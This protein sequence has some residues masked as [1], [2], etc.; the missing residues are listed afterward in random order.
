MRI[1]PSTDIQGWRIFLYAIAIWPMTIGQ[2]PLMLVAPYY[3]FA[4]GMSLTVL[5]AWMTVGRIFDV[6]VDIGV[7]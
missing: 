1:A 3:A 6:F 4:F 2:Q 5:G 7:A